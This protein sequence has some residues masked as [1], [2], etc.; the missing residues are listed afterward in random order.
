MAP[1][2]IPRGYLEPTLDSP[3]GRRP[4]DSSIAAPS[5]DPDRSDRRRVA[6]DRV[7]LA[8]ACATGRPREWPMREIING[9]FYVMRAGCL[10]RHSMKQAVEV[11][12]PTVAADEE[13]QAFA[14]RL[15][16]PLPIPCLTARVICIEPGAAECL[17]AAMRTAFHVAAVLVLLADTGGAVETSIVLHCFHGFL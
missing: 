13:P 3:C 14:V 2:V 10:H 4:L 1:A 5:P 12:G 8:E 9:I 6:R 16:R 15:A 11:G 7:A 17:P